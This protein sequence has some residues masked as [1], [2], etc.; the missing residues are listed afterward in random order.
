[1]RGRCR[2]MHAGHTCRACHDEGGV[3]LRALSVVTFAALGGCAAPATRAASPTPLP[4][5]ARDSRGAPLELAP[6]V[7]DAWQWRARG[8]HVVA[9]AA[10]DRA[11]SE[12]AVLPRAGFEEGARLDACPGGL[13]ASVAT[14]MGVA[15][16]DTTTRTVRGFA[17]GEKVVW[18]N[19]RQVAITR[20]HP[21]SDDT[22]ELFAA[23]SGLLV[24][25]LTNASWNLDATP[26]RLFTL[27]FDAANRP[28]LHPFDLD[29]LTPETALQI[30]PPVAKGLARELS[31]PTPG[32]SVYPGPR[33]VLSPDEKEV[34]AQLGGVV[35]WDAKSPSRPL[36][37]F[38]PFV[39]SNIGAWDPKFRYAAVITW[40]PASETAGIVA[41][42]D[43]STHAVVSTL[44]SCP[45]PQS[46][47]WSGDGSVLAVGDLRRACIF[48]VAS[49]RLLRRT[50]FLRPAWEA[51]DL[52][53]VHTI[54]FA[55]SRL[56]VFSTDD[57]SLGVAR[58]AD[59]KLLARE[60]SSS[61]R[62]FASPDRVY[63]VVDDRLEGVDADGKK[64]TRP[65]SPEEALRIEEIPELAF[66]LEA[67]RKA[68]RAVD[69][70][71]KTVCSVGGLV[72][73]RENCLR[74]K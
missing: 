43:R 46:V 62:W 21:G 6:L 55:G 1:M 52:Q 33:V 27:S 34:M 73:P 8:E 2:A 30:T 68:F 22:V 50:E 17:R 64:T 67:R 66:A 44:D 65:L 23:S 31:D 13:F 45:Y 19:D 71:G 25:A 7:A 60:S 37:T 54:A 38:R 42:I 24:A 72:F 5:S 10:F 57:G 4:A 14:S 28:S 16:V 48:D 40:S 36:F 9:N 41:L 53:A 35:V 58:I 59:G 61:P 49:R 63:W 74:R 18:P 20:A 39:T 15:I 51:D 70:A 32:T 26:H 12:L 3:R 69:A 56:L 29:T 11:L 47:A